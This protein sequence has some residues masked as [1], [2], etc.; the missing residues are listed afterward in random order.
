MGTL[1]LSRRSPSSSDSESEEL[2][3]D[4]E[5]DEDEDDEVSRLR[6]C[7]APELGRRGGRSL[8]GNDTV[9]LAATVLL[10]AGTNDGFLAGGRGALLWLL[11][12]REQQREE[13]NTEHLNPGGA[14]SKPQFMVTTGVPVR[15]ARDS[16][17]D[18][19]RPEGVS[20]RDGLGPTGE[21]PEHKKNS[22]KYP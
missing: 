4:E 17:L 8:C 11:Y 18:R 7:R 13:L 21:R 15:N 12:V 2:E 9:V 20:C 10:P 19:H 1:L 5:E 16:C 22:K 3:E 14:V 6:P